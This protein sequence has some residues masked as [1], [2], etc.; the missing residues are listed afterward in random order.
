MK[1]LIKFVSV[2]VGLLLFPLLTVLDVSVDL[3]KGRSFGFIIM[4]SKKETSEY[5]DALKSIVKA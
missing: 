1:T 3:I 2:L 5:F 4:K